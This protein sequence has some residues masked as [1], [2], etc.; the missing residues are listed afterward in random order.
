MP[1]GSAKA[2]TERVQFL[3]IRLFLARKLSW[4]EQ[5]LALLKQLEATNLGLKQLRDFFGNGVA[6]QMLEVLIEESEAR[7]LELKRMLIQ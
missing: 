3:D 4:N 2:T 1:E 6:R 5:R 7:F